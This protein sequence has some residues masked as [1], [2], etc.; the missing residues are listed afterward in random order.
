MLRCNVLYELTVQGTYYGQEIIARWN[1]N[2]SGIPAAVS[3]S[4]ALVS[5]FG[6]IPEQPGNA[7][8]TDAPFEY[9]RRIQSSNLGYNEVVCKA[10]YDDVDFYTTPFPSGTVGLSSGGADAS[11]MDALGFRTNRVRQDIGRGYKRF[12]APLVAA[13]APGGT[14]VGDTLEAME[15]LGAAMSE[16]LT[17]IDE[18]NTVSFAPCIMG[19]QEYITPSGKKAYRKY[20]TL[21]EQVQHLALGISWEPYDTQRSQ[22]SR[23]YGVGS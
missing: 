14:V 19:K 11:P 4:F 8:P 13:F 5:A 17:Y 23:Q 10:L 15:E 22:R 6:L 1:Y 12:A 3:G 20:P 18:G 7:F 21:A 16:T 9:M 2:S